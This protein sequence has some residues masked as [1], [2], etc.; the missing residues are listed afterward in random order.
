MGNMYVTKISRI[1]LYE[2][3]KLYGH[4]QVNTGRVDR[5]RL[6]TLVILQAMY[7]CSC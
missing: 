7:Y 1:C 6:K 2:K 3:V 5:L 4:L